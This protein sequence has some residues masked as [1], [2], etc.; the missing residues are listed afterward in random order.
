MKRPGLILLSGLVL[1]LL[2]YGGSYL[3]GSARSRAL[4]QSAAPELAWLQTE[5]NIPDREFARIQSLHSAYVLACADRCRRIDETN[6]RLR[7]LIAST[8]SVTA[9]MERAIREAAEVR[10]D[11]H[12]AMLQHF[13]EI[14][15]TMPPDQGKRYLQWVTAATFGSA[16]ASMIQEQE[17]P[18]AA[19]EHHHE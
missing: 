15:R 3:A 17:T 7:G 18:A 9:E 1:A 5:F 19:H 8:N 6:E 11:C 12:R 14:S 13:Y 16:H 10:A 4:A 2:A